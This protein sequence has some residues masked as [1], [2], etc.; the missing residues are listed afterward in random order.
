MTGSSSRAGSYQSLLNQCTISFLYCKFKSVLRPIEDGKPLRQRASIYS[1]ETSVM[2]LHHGSA[3]ARPLC[4][5]DFAAVRSVVHP[6]RM[7]SREGFSFG[8]AFLL[9]ISASSI[10]RAQD[11][12]LNKVH[13]PP[14]VPPVSDTAPNASA[15]PAQPPPVTG[16]DA[17][18]A[19]PGERIRVD[20][21]LVLV[22]LTVTDPL[23]R[24]VTGLDKRQLFSFLR[25]T[26]RR[27]LR[28]FR[29]K[30]P[31]SRSG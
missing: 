29:V 15:P 25:T 30:M 22:P 13:V 11:D 10:C 2:A 5:L 19:R 21:D 23:N 24:L 20:V 9:A 8:L 31:R 27:R 18:K 12:P 1:T 14:P 16:P 6:L 3:A 26:A 17:L 4:E 28:P 7:R